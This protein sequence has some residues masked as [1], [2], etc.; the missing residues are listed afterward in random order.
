MEKNSLSFGE[1]SDKATSLNCYKPNFR[2][3][4]H[5][6]QLNSLGLWTIIFT[7]TATYSAYTPPYARPNTSSP[8]LKSSA[9]ITSGLAKSRAAASILLWLTRLARNYTWRAEPR[10]SHY[11][12]RLGSPWKAFGSLARGSLERL[13]EP[14]SVAYISCDPA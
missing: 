1:I 11:Q 13:A 3:S 8:F 9:N 2:D 6:L 4:G 7:L 10:A 14:V 12:A 5:S